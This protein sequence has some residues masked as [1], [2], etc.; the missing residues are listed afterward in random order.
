[1]APAPAYRVKPDETLPGYSIR[2][3]CTVSE[4]NLT[5]VTSVTKVIVINVT[6]TA[7]GPFSAF[8]YDLTTHLTPAVMTMT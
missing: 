8:D 5:A 6:L 7:V 2:L 4:S 1:M 3:Y